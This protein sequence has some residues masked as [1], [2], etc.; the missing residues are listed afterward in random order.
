[1]YVGI[2]IKKKSCFFSIP[3]ISDQ[4]KED[5]CRL[6]KIFQK[7]CQFIS[8]FLRNKFS[9]LFLYERD[10]FIIVYKYT[11]D[12]AVFLFNLATCDL[13]RIVEENHND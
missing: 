6:K 3:C 13:H 1:M 10:S 5:I 7:H 11:I 12:Y 2:L 8:R 4:V 9:L